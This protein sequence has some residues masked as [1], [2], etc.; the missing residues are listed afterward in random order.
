MERIS[1]KLKLEHSGTCAHDIQETVEQHMTLITLSLNNTYHKRW[2]YNEA[3]QCWEEK[4][5]TSAKVDDV[6]ESIK[7][8]DL[9]VGHPGTWGTA[10]ISNA[11]DFITLTL[12]FYKSEALQSTP[13]KDL[14]GLLVLDIYK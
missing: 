2:H 5:T 7:H 14:L 12:D 8:K 9:V 6:I 10:T 3:W 4:P 1:Q 11:C 13:C